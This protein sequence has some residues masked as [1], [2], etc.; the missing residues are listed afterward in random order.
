[1]RSFKS[2]LGEELWTAGEQADAAYLT[3][4]RS[5]HKGLHQLLAAAMILVTLGDGD[6]TNFG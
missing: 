5:G 1:L 3:L 2:Q 4:A 6:R